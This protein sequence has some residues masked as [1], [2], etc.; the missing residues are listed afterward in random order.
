MS[1]ISIHCLSLYK[2][3]K[4]GGPWYLTEKSKASCHSRGGTMKIP[5]PSGGSRN[6]CSKAVDAIWQQFTGNDDASI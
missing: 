5:L 6:P 2:E 3:T 1:S 4:C